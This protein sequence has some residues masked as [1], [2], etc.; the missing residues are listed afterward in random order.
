MTWADR[1]AARPRAP[2]S[3]KTWWGCD[4]PLYQAPSQDFEAN[5]SATAGDYELWAV[6]GSLNGPLT[7]TVSAKLVGQVKSQDGYVKNVI[8]GNDYQTRTTRASAGRCNTIPPT[9]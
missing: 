4:Q 8:D 9:I 3:A 5:V 6:Q 7:D 1:G 2:C